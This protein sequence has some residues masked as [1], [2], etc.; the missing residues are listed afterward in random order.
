MTEVW[1]FRPLA[2]LSVRSLGARGVYGDAGAFEFGAA[3]E[4]QGGGDD[5]DGREGGLQDRLRRDEA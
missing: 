1:F 5:R 4:D 2:L 3:A